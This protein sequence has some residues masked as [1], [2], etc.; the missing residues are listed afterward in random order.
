MLDIHSKIQVLEKHDD[1]SRPS[2]YLY[3]DVQSFV[4]DFI[5]YLQIHDPRFSFRRLAKRAGF[6]SPNYFQNLLKG[7]KKITERGVDQLAKG[8]SLKSEETLYLRLL[9]LFRDAETSEARA[10]L[11]KRLR[12]LQSLQ[13]VDKIQRTRFEY[14]NK[15]Y[16]PVIREMIASGSFPQD[17]EEASQRIF[18][19][20]DAL[21]IKYGLCILESLGF[22]RYEDPAGWVSEATH[23]KTELETASLIV[24]KFHQEMLQ[25]ATK[26]IDQIPSHERH[27]SSLTMSVS[28]KRYNELVQY[29]A[30][31]KAEIAKRF[32]DV[33][34]EDAEVYQLN[35]QLFPLTRTPDKK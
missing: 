4:S 32:A 11:Q 6:G 20:V 2:V 27:V 8:F 5:R 23:L 35:L 33:Q 31:V 3:T 7:E 18:P 19:R 24:R 9:I 14:Y 10:D 15:W 13:S 26:S 21:D 16:I 22:V 1:Q 17:C 34:L 29:I 25:L 28:K 30:S 12:E